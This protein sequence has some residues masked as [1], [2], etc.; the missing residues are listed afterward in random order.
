VP[1]AI[2]SA[3]GQSAN[4]TEWRNA[5]GSLVN[6]I[7]KN[8]DLGL[9]TSNPTDKLTVAGSVSPSSS[10]NYNLGSSS[11]RWNQV[12]ATNGTINTSDR[13]MKKNIQ[14]LRYGLKEV[15]NLQP[16]SYNWKDSA[17][18]EN[19]IGLIAQD[20]R[21][22][23][24]EVVVGDETKE[25]LGMNYAELV[26]VLINAIKEQQKQIDELKKEKI[27]EQNTQKELEGLKEDMKALIGK[28]R[29]L[30]SKRAD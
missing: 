6:V 9:G 2:Q 7:N 16:V 1:L 3:S 22:V 28:V 25:T 24:P 21:K 20:V 17:H 15:M 18:K 10:G 13:R 30:E 23:I 8:G 27:K 29:Q 11:S 4:L 12:Y 5:A 26:P 14:N 19:K